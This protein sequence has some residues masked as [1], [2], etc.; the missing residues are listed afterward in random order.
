[1]K[2]FADGPGR[3]R[4]EAIVRMVR[5][6]I[7]ARHFLEVFRFRRRLGYFPN[8]AFPRTLYEKFLW[9]KIFDRSPLIGR[10]TDKLEAKA[11]FAEKCPSLAQAEVVWTGENAEDIP[12]S[13]LEGDVI[14]K[15]NCGSGQNAFSFAGEQNHQEIRDTLKRW[16][17]QRRPYGKKRLEWGYSQVSRKVFVERLIRDDRGEAPFNVQIHAA[18]GE[19]AMAHVWRHVTEGGDHHGP[20]I[21]ALYDRDGNRLGVQP[22]WKGKPTPAFPAGFRATDT[23]EEVYEHARVASLGMD[24]IRVDFLCTPNKAFAGELT[25]YSHAGYPR[26]SV[27]EQQKTLSDVWDLRKSWFLTSPQPGWRGTYARAL[28]RLLDD[29]DAR[30]SGA[31]SHSHGRNR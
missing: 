21:A 2:D 11:Y 17:E 20:D 27:P 19:I 31:S 9:R 8:G 15:S 16:I 18:D 10:L 6:W 23:M 22:M 25:F 12:D 28:R 5:V 26:W 14:V 24:Y 1:M 13:A 3:R 29:A 7:N 4:D 30:S